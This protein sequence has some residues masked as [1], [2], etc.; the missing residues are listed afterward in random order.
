MST[1][2]KAPAWA[3]AVVCLLMAGVLTVCLFIPGPAD[4]LLVLLVIAAM[5][6]FKPDMRADFARAVPAAWKA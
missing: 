4:E 1:Q 5:A 6:A 3:L 2:A